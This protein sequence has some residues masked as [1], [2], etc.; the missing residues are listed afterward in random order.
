MLAWMQGEGNRVIRAPGGEHKRG[1][2]PPR[3]AWVCA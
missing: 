2:P 3:L 1:A